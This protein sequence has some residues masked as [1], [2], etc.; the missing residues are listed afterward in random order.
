MSRDVQNH[1][2]LRLRASFALAYCLTFQKESTHLKVF[3]DFL[4]F[5]VS[6]HL[7]YSG[8]YCPFIGRTECTDCTTAGPDGQ[9][10]LVMQFDKAD[11]VAAIG[12]AGAFNDRDCVVIHLT[13]QLISGGDLVAEDVVR[14]QKRR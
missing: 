9:L 4:S 10:D 6:P 2:T 1:S 14:I 13:A 3:A 5:E 12:G 8:V 11:V 7:A